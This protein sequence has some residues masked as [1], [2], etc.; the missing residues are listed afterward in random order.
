MYYRT[1]DPV[2]DAARY[3]DELDKEYQIASEK[4]HCECC[5]KACGG[6]DHFNLWGDVIACSYECALKLLSED[7][8]EDILLDWIE[9]QSEGPLY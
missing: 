6:D 9:D 4:A 7:D 1:D 5:G 3:Y 8:K 2:R